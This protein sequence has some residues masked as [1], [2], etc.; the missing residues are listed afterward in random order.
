MPRMV[1]KTYSLAEGIERGC[2]CTGLM[3]SGTTAGLTRFGVQ[4]KV[5]EE[6]GWPRACRWVAVFRMRE[7][8]EV[9]G[10]IVRILAGDWDTWFPKVDQAVR[11]FE[12]RTGQVVTIEKVWHLTYIDWGV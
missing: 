4:M 7:V 1:D 5:D 2:I 9:D 11:L 12:E 6:R 3:L 8:A 10:L